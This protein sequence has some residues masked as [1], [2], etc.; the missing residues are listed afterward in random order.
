MPLTA[1]WGWTALTCSWMRPTVVPGLAAVP[2]CLD[3]FDG[4]AGSTS[5]VGVKDCRGRT[6]AGC[7]NPI[8]NAANRLTATYFGA[9]AT[10][11]NLGG[12]SENVTMAL[13]NLIQPPTPTHSLT[14]DTLTTTWWWAA[15]IKSRR[16]AAPHLSSALP[17]VRQRRTLPA[18]QSTTLLLAARHRR[19]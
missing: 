1:A 9:A 11:I 14:P 6:L 19:R 13:G 8:G 5:T 4:P 7:D 18:L 15:P 2:Q 17:L 10:S 12:G 16:P 3:I